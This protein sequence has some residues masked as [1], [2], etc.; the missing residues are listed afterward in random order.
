MRA[1]LTTEGSPDSRLQSSL[2]RDRL[3]RDSRWI[4]DQGLRGVCVYDCRT[5]YKAVRVGGGG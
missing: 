4:L 3:H 2:A 5:Y 1:C